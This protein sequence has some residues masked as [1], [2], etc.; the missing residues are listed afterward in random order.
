MSISL[1]DAIVRCSNGAFRRVRDARESSPGFRGP[2]CVVESMESRVLP[3]GNGLLATYWDNASSAYT[4]SL[5]FSGKSVHR[6]DA[7]INFNWG[8]GSP[9]SGIGANTFSV[10]WSGQIAVPRTGVYRFYVRADDGAK[11]WVNGV[12]L[13]NAWNGHRGGELSARISLTGGRRYTIQMESYDN[14]GQA[15]AQ[16]RWSGPGVAKTLVPQRVL[17]STAPQPSAAAKARVVRTSASPDVS[18]IAVWN[19]AFGDSRSAGTL[20]SSRH[21]L[22]ATHYLV[23]TGTT[24]RWPSGDTAVIVAMVSIPGTDITVG[25]LDHSL[26]GRNR[27]LPIIQYSGAGWVTNQFGQVKPTR[28]VESSRSVVWSTPLVSG[29][30]GHPVL[31]KTTSGVTGVVSLASHATSGTSLWAIRGQIASARR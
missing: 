6:T 16:L 20:I 7:S 25:T 30:S 9:A 22:Y 29:D 11:L 14:S 15:T 12:Q 13:V 17:Y 4:S 28:I 18:G 24:L 26:P 5:N 23:P 21:V 10:R 31:A 19:S 3:A 8:T 2:G 1:I 27:P